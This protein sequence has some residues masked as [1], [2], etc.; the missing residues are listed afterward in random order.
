M[1]KSLYETLGLNDN[2]DASE[3][4]KAY[5]KLAKKYHPDLN[6]S[7]EAEEKFK[8]INGAYEVLSDSSKKQQYDQY[9][10]SMFGGQN[11]HD[12]AQGQGGKGMDLNDILN[13]LFGGS[14]GRQSAG[15]FESMF[16]GGGFGGYQT[17]DLDITSN[18]TIPFAT[19]LEGGKYSV[20]VEGANFDVKIPAGI[21]D[22][23]KLRVKGKGRSMQ[24]HTG[25][26]F[27][28][29]NISKD[30]RFERNNDDLY[31]TTPIDLKTALFGGKIDV[32]TPY[33]SVSLKVPRNT[34]PNQKF[35][36]KGYGVT[37]RST[38]EKGNLYVSVELK[39]PNV[40]ELS[41][42]TKE[43]LQKI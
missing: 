31:T 34:Q 26:L 42:E 1:S 25:D 19:V 43:I 39:L 12:F 21:K 17:P 20:Q 24:G 16:G 7:K 40:D 9:G 6:P 41:D 11:F 29:V 36:I 2:A 3:I 22:K 32:I 18:I 23:E 38:K 35:R 28:V 10:D 27:L 15:G 14:G 37:N 33:K 8:E 13:N 30:D 5:R 4:K